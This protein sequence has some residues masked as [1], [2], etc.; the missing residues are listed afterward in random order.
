MR[1]GGKV[2]ELQEEFKWN[3]KR[4]EILSFGEAAAHRH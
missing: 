2:V 1:K 4:S 3:K